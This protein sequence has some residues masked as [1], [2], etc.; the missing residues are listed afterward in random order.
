VQSEVQQLEGGKA[1]AVSKIDL[2]GKQFHLLMFALEELHATLNEEKQ[3]EAAA[4]AAATAVEPVS[5]DVEPA[6]DPMVS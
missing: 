4:A 2:R 5:G 1:R 3:A 6:A